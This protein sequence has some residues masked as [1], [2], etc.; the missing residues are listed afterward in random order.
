MD[1]CKYE[2]ELGGLLESKENFEAFMKEIRD[3]H[4]THIYKKLEQ[5]AGRPT[6]IVVIIITSLT[7]LNGI[8]ITILANH[9]LGGK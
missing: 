6:W 4:L 1:P 9:L 8:L 7:T 2:K 5:L 3:N